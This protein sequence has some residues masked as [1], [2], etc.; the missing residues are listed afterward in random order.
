MRVVTS[1]VVVVVCVALCRPTLGDLPSEMQ[2]A[3]G[4]LEAAVAEVTPLMVDGRA[5]EA[6]ARLLAVFPEKTRTAAQSLLLGNV[7]YLQDP[8]VSYALH[9]AAAAALPGEPDVQLEW[10]L[11]QHRAGQWA[12]ALAA[13]DKVVAAQPGYGPLQGMRAECLIRTGQ[14]KAAAEAWAKSERGGGSIETL[15][16][17]VCE[18]HMHEVPDR[19]RAGLFAKAKGGDAAAAVSLVALDCA[20][21]RDW[22]NDGPRSDYLARDLT[23]IGATKFADSDA[24]RAATCAVAC[25]ELLAREDGGG[26]AAAILKPA[27][28]L[29]DAKHTLPADG[30][31]LSVML[32]SAESTHA[33]TNAQAREQLGPAVLARARAT[34][35]A[36]TFNVAAHL[37]LGT[38]QLA[39]IDQE[40]WDAT[41]DV[42]FAASR[43]AGLRETGQL[44]P[45]DSRLARAVK[46]FPDDA[47]I[48]G[49][50]VAGAANPQ[51]ALVAAIKAEF[52]HFSNAGG[53]VGGRPSAIPVRVYFRQLAKVMGVPAGR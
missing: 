51:A 13:Y 35:D 2:A 8:E 49:L 45:N 38:D 40:G 9:K 15:E 33:L 7:L 12:G 23:L 16:S 50:A 27:G 44:V 10:A 17:W 28:F 19:D 20:F 21:R 29:L 4:P 25:G 11:E 22:W 3:A 14:V 30:R 41:G 5:A 52:T 31:L 6:N 37:Y 46:Q 34:K 18:V 36:A 43:I 26:D 48:A 53:F 1:F 47:T 24:I 39:A 42:R 32:A